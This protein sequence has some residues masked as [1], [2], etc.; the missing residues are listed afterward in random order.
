M[1]GLLT[2]NLGSQMG[3]FAAMYC[4]SRRSG[5]RIVFFKDYAQIGKKLQCHLHFRKFPLEVVAIEDMSDEDRVFF[6]LPLTNGYAVDPRVFQLDPAASYNFQGLFH[7]YKYWYPSIRELTERFA[8][9][10]Q[11]LERASAIVAAAR[12]GGRQVVAVHVRRADYVGG[13]HVNLTRDYYDAAFQQFSDL[14]VNYL[15][16]SD[17]VPWCREHFGDRANVHYSEGAEAIVDMAAMSLCDHHVIANSSFSYWGALLCQDPRKRVVC[18]SRF[19]RNDD[20]IPYLNYAWYPDG[21]T[22]LDA[23]NV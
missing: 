19:L 5:H 14:A 22:G 12:T 16:F 1:T 11:V 17:D 18:P 20:I 3:N 23:G 13:V 21:W 10:P 2:E 6:N 9:D 7:S 8:F 4:I 15:L